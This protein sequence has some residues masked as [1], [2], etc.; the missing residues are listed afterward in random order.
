VEQL[1]TPFPW[2]V[3]AVI[4]LVVAAAMIIH[5]VRTK[6]EKAVSFDEVGGVLKQDWTRTGKIDFHVAAPN[7]TKP[8]QLIL[9][10]EE[11]K[12]IEN[13]MGE[14]VV[15]LRWR[16]ATV[17]EAKEVVICWNKHHGEDRPPEPP[18]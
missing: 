1:T 15:Q 12:I 18:R 13:P 6:D 8:Q 11:K 16:F 10:V 4:A 14:D 2:G 7:S 17:D 5:A 9:R 3:I